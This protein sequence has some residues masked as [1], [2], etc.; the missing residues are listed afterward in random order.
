[1]LN[2]QEIRLEPVEEEVLESKSVR[3]LTF[4]YFS[5]VFLAVNTLCHSVLA[6]WSITEREAT[7]IISAQLLSRQRQG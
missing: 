2:L 4:F 1:M 7:L 5:A 6:W 3:S